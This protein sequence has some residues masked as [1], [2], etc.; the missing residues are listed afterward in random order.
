MRRDNIKARKN[1][2]ITLNSG[3]LHGNF[4]LRQPHIWSKYS[5]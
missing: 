3:T 1:E 5:G 4:F 2:R